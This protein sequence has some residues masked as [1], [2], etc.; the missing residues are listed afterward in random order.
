[1][2]IFEEEQKSDIAVAEKVE[3]K[4]PSQY[5]VIVHNNDDTSYD[6]VILI[7]SQ[8]FEISHQEALDIARKVDKD[9]QGLCGTYSKEIAEMKLVIVNM[10]KDSLITLFPQRQKQI[11]MLKFTVEKS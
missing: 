8:S 7:L 4:E 6:E 9:G 1:M 11:T 10:V 2:N 5:D 3:I